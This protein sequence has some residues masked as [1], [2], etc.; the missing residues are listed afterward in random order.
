[1]S[2]VPAWPHAHGGPPLIGALRTTPEDFIVE[3]LPSVAPDDGGEHDWLWVRKQ[4]ANTAWLAGELARFAGVSER[5][6]G[7]AG[8]KDRHALTTQA[9]TVHLPGRASPEW[10]Q[11][12]IP[13]VTVLSQ[14]R[15]SRKLKRG[16]LRGNRFELRV[17]VTDGDRAALDDRVGR[18]QRYGVPNYFG[19]QRFGRDGVNVERAAALFA[20]QRMRRSE[21]EMLISAAR[22]AVFNAVLS[23]R[24]RDGSWDRG[25]PGEVWSLAGSRSWFGPDVDDDDLEHRRKIGD[26]HPSGPLWGRGELP[27]ADAALA[28]ER[29]AVAPYQTL[30]EGLASVGLAQDR[31]ALRL[32]PEALIATWLDPETLGLAFTLPPGTYATVVVR[33]LVAVAQPPNSPPSPPPP[34]QFSASS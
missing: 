32:M 17:R 23:Q 8:R 9:F 1:M 29:A 19:E 25:L 2:G 28:V 30:C 12:S 31:R 21:R 34:T 18:L 33:E 6:V 16:A 26:I 3:E 15:H 27:T 5:D 24:V 20:G 13:G 10:S 11:L 22:S 7:Y 4:G 14:R